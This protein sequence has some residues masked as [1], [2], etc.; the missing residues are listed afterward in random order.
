[1]RHLAFAERQKPKSIFSIQTGILSSRKLLGAS[2]LAGRG[3]LDPLASSTHHLCFAAGH[4]LEHLTDRHG[5]LRFWI[6]D[7]YELHLCHL[8]YF[9]RRGRLSTPHRQPAWFGEY[10]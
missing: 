3:N 10:P 1:M 9:C 6:S 2:A 5:R 4:L 7:L 8:Y